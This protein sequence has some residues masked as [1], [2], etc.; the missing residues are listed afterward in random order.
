MPDDARLDL[1]K[2]SAAR[3][4][5]HYLGG[6]HHYPVDE[7]FAA[8]VVALCPFTPDLAIYNRGF[9]TRAVEALV[10]AGIRQFIDVGSG[11][12]TAPN[13]H[14]IAHATAPDSRV[15]YVDF[16]GEAIATAQRELAG[17]PHATMIHGDLRRPE[18]ILDNPVLHGMLDLTEPVGLLLVAVLNFVAPGDEPHALVARYLDA[19][20]SGS[21]LVASHVSV[22]EATEE[23]RRQLRAGQEAYGSTPLPSTARSKEEFTRFFAGLDLFDP[24]VSF[25]ADWRAVK[26]VAADDPARPCFYAAVGRKP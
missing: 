23:A 12:P 5:D 10:S 8:R 26:P 21:H 20:P 18:T 16:D 14:Q 17:E 22:E 19:L 24:G 9:L 11:I 3:L 13:V 2:P 15:V 6:K 7:E 1:T 25:A 4:Y